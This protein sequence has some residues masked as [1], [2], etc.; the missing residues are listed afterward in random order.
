MRHGIL[1]DAELAGR[2]MR[3]LREVVASL[4]ARPVLALDG[5]LAAVRGAIETYWAFQADDDMERAE[6]MARFTRRFDAAL[7]GVAA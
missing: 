7:A 1:A 3:Q 2:G 6:G 5:D 4:A